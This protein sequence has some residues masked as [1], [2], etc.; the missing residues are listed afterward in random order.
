MKISEK[1]IVNGNKVVSK[2]GCWEINNVDI[3]QVDENGNKTKIG[4]YI[5]Q[6]P[7]MFN[8]FVP[9]TQNGKEYA[10]YSDDYTCTKVMEL[11]SCKQIAGETPNEFGFC[12]VDFFVPEE[13]EKVGLKGRFGFVAGCV[14]GDD[15]SWKIQYLDL[16]KISEGKLRR[17]NRF[18]YI[19][20][21]GNLSLS[22]AIDMSDFYCPND[23]ED[24]DYAYVNIA[25]GS[26]HSV[27]LIK[28]E[29]PALLYKDRVLTKEEMNTLLS[30][31][32]P[33]VVEGKFIGESFLRYL[34]LV[35]DGKLTLDQIIKYLTG[36][37][38]NLR[39]LS[40]EVLKVIDGKNE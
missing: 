38:D 27:A 33:Q 20:L 25:C 4:E 28:E 26:R 9:F 22:G 30:A 23:N 40:D 34:N 6:Y 31:L 12:P 19:E 15:S 13:D 36:R 11:P 24:D 29:V 39:K 17:E 14:W 1:Y 8:T 2:P 7:S 21:P 3:F 18:G 5:R 10:L 35:K 37:A 16:S 32:R